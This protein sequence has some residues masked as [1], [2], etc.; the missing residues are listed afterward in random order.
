MLEVEV[1]KL[2]TREAFNQ[3]H[4]LYVDTYDEV[5]KYVV[6]HV[7]SMS[8][9][10]D[11]IQDIYMAVF[12]KIKKHINREYVFG[13]AKHKVKDYYRFRYR[14]EKDIWNFTDEIEDISDNLD[15]LEFVI[16]VDQIDFVWDYLKHKNCLIG[17]IFFLYYY[18]NCSLKEIAYLLE[19]T[20]SNVKHYLYRTLKEI[21]V[22]LKEEGGFHE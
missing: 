9:V 18:Q 14:R 21:Q 5:L 20:E 4:E 6:C 10:E 15:I 7:R 16:Q 1:D 8:D 13:I 3:F 22:I 2:N 11:V 17:K 19:I 12:K